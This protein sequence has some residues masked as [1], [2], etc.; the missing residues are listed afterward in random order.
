[1][2]DFLDGGLF[3]LFE[4][5]VGRFDGFL[6]FHD[7]FL[8]VL[9]IQLCVRVGRLADLNLDGHQI[10]HLIV[11]RVLQKYCYR[12]LLEVGVVNQIRQRVSVFLALRYHFVDFIPADA[13][14]L[15]LSNDV[16]DGI[17]ILHVHFNQLR[18]VH[19]IL[20]FILQ[21]LDSALLVSLDVLI[22]FPD[23]FFFFVLLV[24]LKLEVL[25]VDVD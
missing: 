19:I 9:I 20:L 11:A 15:H 21:L 7:I 3:R 17:D 6:F 16:C 23:Q 4:R 14:L 2:L 24:C 8:F 22:F 10:G 5:L 12:V 13:P 18:L 1:M 25:V